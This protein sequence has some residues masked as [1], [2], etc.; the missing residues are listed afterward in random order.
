MKAVLDANLFFSTWITDPLLSFA[1]S[2]YYRPIWSERILGE[3]AEHLPDVWAHASEEDVLGYLDMIRKAFPEAMVEGWERHEQSISL[4]D[5]DDRHVVAAAVEA[6]AGTI[7]T[8]NIKHFPSSILRT[9]GI[10]ATTPDSFLSTLY[11][12]DEEES[13]RLMHELI[14]SKRH[15]PRT[16][17]E[18]IR[19]LERLGLITFAAKLRH[20]G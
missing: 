2:G 18:E 3:V 17:D 14:R 6:H 5:V 1:E 19:H 16:M 15:P 11:E 4:P 13:R 20:M 7:V 9:Y 12:E 10:K 8:A